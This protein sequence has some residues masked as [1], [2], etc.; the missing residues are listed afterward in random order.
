MLPRKHLGCSGPSSCLFR[1]LKVKRLS[2][3]RRGGGDTGAKAVSRPCHLR[4]DSWAKYV[5]ISKVLTLCP[6]SPISFPRDQR[7]SPIADYLG[8]ILWPI[9]HPHLLSCS[10]IHR[11]TL[12]VGAEK[13]QNEASET[14]W[15]PSFCYWTHCADVGA[16]VIKRATNKASRLKR[17]GNSGQYSLHRHDWVCRTMF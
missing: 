3:L 9:W 14:Y 17:R 4:F 16:K 7:G 11:A 13:C 12:R 2:G 1:G 6:L 5:Q 8:G 15:P 10:Q